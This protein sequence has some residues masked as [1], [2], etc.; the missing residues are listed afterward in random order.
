MNHHLMTI[1]IRT[2]KSSPTRAVPSPNQRKPQTRLLLSL[3]TLT[4]A[5]CAPAMSEDM[6]DLDSA[7]AA[8]F[9]SEIHHFDF[10][11]FS[12]SAVTDAVTGHTAQVHGTPVRIAGAD[13]T[14]RGAL[15]FNQ[16]T[17]FEQPS[18]ATPSELTLSAWI[19]DTDNGP[20]TIVSKGDGGNGAITDYIFLIENNIPMFF[21]NGTW[22]TASSSLAAGWN[23]VAV[24]YDGLHV[25]FYING[26]TAGQIASPGALY[27]GSS[28]VIVGR[29]GENCQCNRFIG[30]MDEIRIFGHALSSQEIQTIANAPVTAAYYPMDG[31][32]AVPPV[33]CAGDP[34]NPGNPGGA[35][36]EMPATAS[37]SL[38]NQ[39]SFSTGVSGSGLRF[40]PGAGPVTDT[41][42]PAT[43]P[44]ALTLSAWL[45]GT[46][47][48]PRTIVSK[49]HGGDGTIT[50][51]I[52]AAENGTLVFYGNG[53]WHTATQPLGSGWNHVAVTYDGD[54][55]RFYINAQDAGR[56]VSPGALY[57]GSS[58]TLLGVQGDSCQCNPFIGD[59]DEVQIFSKV[60]T[61]DAITL[62]YAQPTTDP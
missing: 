31:F 51:Y 48:A 50:D 60:L 54:Q 37:A 2:T 15:R 16:N 40:M 62:L 56:I 49:G 29:Q 41:A 4:L 36:D 22:H 52:F 9:A 24:T 13:G 12:N 39:C 34:G 42:P 18:S 45:R 6:S 7:N 33:L 21:G 19:G 38:V 55:V 27:A 32:S 3:L 35:L 46:D 5:A 10:N 57:A 11:E 28:P 17:Y 44:H 8:L 14:R 53:G 23:H 59:M 26:N 1:S 58:S 30:D 43:N 47:N 61:A 25:R 20:R